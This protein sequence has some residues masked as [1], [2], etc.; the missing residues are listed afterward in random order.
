MIVL[1]DGASFKMSWKQVR[2]TNHNN[3]II[4]QIIPMFK[5]SDIVIVPSK[6]RWEKIQKVFS[7]EEREEILF[8]L[9]HIVW[10]RDIKILEMD[11]IAETDKETD[12]MSG[13]I[14]GTEGYKILERENLF[15]AD[16]A[17]DKEQVKLL[18]C[19]LE[20]KFA[21]SLTG[22]VCV[23][24]NTIIDGS[25]MSEVTVPTLRENSRAEMVIV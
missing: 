7:F 3:F 13:M 22:V 6:Q 9:E 8:L 4:F 11:I 16:S 19:K 2:Y 21:K 25:I 20:E 23:P 15:D 12:F 14:E 1:P 5:S 18:Y 10:K 24:R 17:L